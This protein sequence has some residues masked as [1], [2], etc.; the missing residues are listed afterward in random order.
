MC[1]LTRWPPLC[2]ESSHVEMAVARAWGHHASP[3]TQK[4]SQGQLVLHVGVTDHFANKMATKLSSQHVFYNFKMD[5][6]AT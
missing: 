3:T 5:F 1:A 4:D 2:T 6:C